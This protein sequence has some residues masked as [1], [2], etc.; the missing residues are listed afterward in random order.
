VLYPESK[1]GTE[2]ML[3]DEAEILLLQRENL[4]DDIKGLETE[5][6]AVENKIKA[7][8]GDNE[9]GSVGNKL[10]T[11]KSISSNRVDTKKLKVE[12]PA[13]YNQYVKET[14]YRKFD[15]KEIKGGK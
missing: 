11:W 6:D 5:L 4:K 8:L 2:I 1:Q 13:I 14:S 12:Q 10:V 9:S 15:V 3:P 7:M